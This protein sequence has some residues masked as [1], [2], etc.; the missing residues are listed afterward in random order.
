MKTIIRSG[1]VE[2]AAGD[3][4][5]LYTDNWVDEHT[6]AV[7]SCISQ[8]KGQRHRS[9]LPLDRK[10]R[11]VK[12]VRSLDITSRYT[13]AKILQTNF[14]ISDLQTAFLHHGEKTWKKPWYIRQTSE[15]RLQSSLKRI[16]K[17]MTIMGK[18]SLGRRG[19]LTKYPGPLPH[20][21]VLQKSQHSVGHHWT[22]RFS[23]LIPVTLSVSSLA[24]SWT[25]QFVLLH[26]SC[27]KGFYKNCSA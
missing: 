4:G 1:K 8:P 12:V 7:S 17:M 22:R 26:L 5:V 27:H 20:S 19:M 14:L 23:P 10:A 11:A 21:A 6:E 15:Q 13:K 3:S 9:F 25:K 18:E 16:Q 2:M 24:S